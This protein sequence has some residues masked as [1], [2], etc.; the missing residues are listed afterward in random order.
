[1]PNGGSFTVTVGNVPAEADAGGEPQDFV[2]IQFSDTGVGIPPNLLSKIFDPFFTTKEV[3][4]GTGLGL[5]Q[6]YGFVHQAGGT[7]NAES[8]VGQGTTITVYLPA[9]S[10]KD[11]AGR[12]IPAKDAPRAQRPTVLIVDDSAEVA[13]VTSSLFERLGYNTD[14]RDSAD[15]ALKYLAE[16]S[17][18]DLVFSD[19]VMPGTI[20]GV[21]LAREIRSRYPN[22]PVVL[23]TGY[24]DAAQAAPADLKILRKPFDTVMLRGFIADTMAVDLAS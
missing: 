1:M 12:E 10:A 19:I 20:D 16:G 13:E 5:S 8:K 24:S 17:K 14:Y 11:I 2:A 21:G 3:G 15:A 22:L 6:V 7:I 18:I 4:K 23:T 9:C